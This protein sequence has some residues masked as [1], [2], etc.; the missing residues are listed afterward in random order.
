MR[1]ILLFVLLAPLFLSAQ[2]NSSSFKIKNPG[3]K[4]SKKCK[5]YFEVYK[6]L[7]S[8]VRYNVKVIDGEIIF[9]FPSEDHFRKI[10][11]N[12]YDGIAIDIIRREQFDCGSENQL[13]DSWAYRG[14]PL[15]PVFWP[16]IE[17]RM[18]VDSQNI[19][20]VNFGKLP[21]QFDPLNVECN[22]LLIQ[23]KYLCGYHTFSNI[24]YNKWGL[25]EMGLYRDSLSN[26]EK[27]NQLENLKKLVFQIPF[28]KNKTIFERTDI[29]PLYD[30][31]NLTEYNIKKIEIE[32]F[33]SVEGTLNNNIALQNARSQ[34]IVDALQ[35]Y[36]TEEIEFSTSSSENWEEF[37]QDIEGTSFQY[38]SR[39]PK[40]AIKNKLKGLE[41]SESMNAILSSHRKAIVKL[42]LQKKFTILEISDNELIDFFDQS[43]QRQQLDR[44][45]YIQNFI[46]E[47]IEKKQLPDDFIGKLEIPK[48]SFY[49]PL[50]NNEA[51]FEY[52]RNQG[53]IS[54][55]I[56]VFEDL[57]FI[58]PNN[59]KIKYNLV[60][61]K[62]KLWK[63]SKLPT[64]RK[65]IWELVRSLERSQLD[66]SLV[67]RLKVNYH[68]ILTE[69]LDH[70]NEFKAKNSSLRQVYQL[71]RGLQLDD[72]DLLILAK[73]LSIYSQFKW[74]EQV[75]SKR[76]YEASVSSKLS[77]Y[78]LRLTIDKP[79]KLKQTR[80]RSLIDRILNTSKQTFCDL[81]LTTAQGGFTFQL[82]SN[83]SLKELY[84]QNCQRE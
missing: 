12:K 6:K 13:T 33:S 19:V 8:E 63:V 2:D 79:K 27:S 4:Q 5:K 44:A 39:R 34:S 11:D 42:E 67:T 50:I 58:L 47:K 25:L 37:Y 31:L 53:S 1:R 30:S 81:F 73:Y 61:L 48:I 71:Y 32:A 10:F 68:I 9:Y 59:A 17:A 29:Q 51:V 62:I 69:I 35:S 78:Y 24:D 55:H 66:R 83:D 23:K 26:R 36:Q 14:S 46:F 22:M 54:N 21:D 49:G 72:A 40:G 80:Y 60:A 41:Q 76:A 75:L 28:E 3:S 52:E 18:I 16:E 82:L 38:L 7:P 70:E 57:L 56:S 45:L 64:L 84:C 65:E 43:V 20:F 77:N 74:A 15:P